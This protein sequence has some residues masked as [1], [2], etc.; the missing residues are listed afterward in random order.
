M[1]RVFESDSFTCNY[2]T[3]KVFVDN[4]NHGGIVELAI[5][6]DKEWDGNE[7]DTHLEVE[8]D[9][10]SIDALIEALQ[11]AKKVALQ[12]EIEEYGF[13]RKHAL[14]VKSPSK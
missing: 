10:T 12:Q 13:A 6:I 1:S 9:Q 2:N 3:T 8:L 4:Q 11:E 7:Q 5:T 14:D